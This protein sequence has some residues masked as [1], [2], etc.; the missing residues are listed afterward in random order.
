MQRRCLSAGVSLWS[1][2]EEEENQERCL[3]FDP[4][5]RK[6]GDKDAG[7]PTS[8]RAGINAKKIILRGFKRDVASPPPSPF[9]GCREALEP[10]Y[11]WENAVEKYRRAGEYT[12][13]STRIGGPSRLT[14]PPLPSGHFLFYFL[15]QRRSSLS[16]FVLARMKPETKSDFSWSE[17]LLVW[18]MHWSI[19]K[20]PA[21]RQN[22]FDFQLLSIHF[23]AQRRKKK[24]LYL[25]LL[26]FSYTISE[27][28]VQLI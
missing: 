25:N 2:R 23:R 28:H 22:A 8:E 21:C 14:P 15:R 20:M 1:R 6:R 18:L 24:Q 4:L 3:K 13:H 19:D 27:L 17:K 26:I 7:N 11:S 9:Q 10:P 5:S 12:P 16:T